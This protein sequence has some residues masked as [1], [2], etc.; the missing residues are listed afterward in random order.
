MKLKDIVNI[1]E[2][3]N[4][5][6][7]IIRVIRDLNTN[8]TT[9]DR[10]R[11][12]LTREIKTYLGIRQGDS[13]SPMLFNL[14][15][16]KIAE[17]IRATAQGYRTGNHEIRLLCYA[18]LIAN[19]ED[20]LQRLLQTFHRTAHIYNMEISKTKTKSMVIAREPIRCKL[21]IDDS[22]I[23]QSMTFDYLGSRLSSKGDLTDDAKRNINKAAVISAYGGAYGETE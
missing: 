12:R 9:Q 21:V 15:M 19:S 6:K 8:N 20:D 13:L 5:S 7:N 10:V 16:D 22:P 11:D 2:E 4:A 23:E 3:K 18:V 14:I 17:I 1:L